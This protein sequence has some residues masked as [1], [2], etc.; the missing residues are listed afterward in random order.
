[1]DKSLRKYVPKAC[2]DVPG[3]DGKVVAARFDGH[4]VVKML[5]FD[6]RMDV[7]EKVAA[8]GEGSVER[9]K[10]MRAFCKDS[11]SK[12]VEVDLKR[13]S[14]GEEIKSFDD[15]EYGGDLN[16]IRLE[17]ASGLIYGFDEGNG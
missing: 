6:E 13:K 16:A 5:T 1:M 4:I 7:L 17:V 12:F 11:A 3:D 8:I 10:F 15:L 14:N 2:R 9:L